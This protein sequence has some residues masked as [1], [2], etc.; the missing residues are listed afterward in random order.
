MTSFYCEAHIDINV[1]QAAKFCLLLQEKCNVKVFWVLR[2][3][4]LTD[5]LAK[6]V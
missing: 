5:F 2:R 4:V 3:N 1:T 6:H